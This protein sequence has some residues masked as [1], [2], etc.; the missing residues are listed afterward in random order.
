[1]RSNQAMTGPSF[2]YLDSQ[3]RA[4][5]MYPEGRVFRQSKVFASD[6]ACLTVFEAG[7]RSNPTVLLI[8]ALGMSGLFLAPLAK[9]LSGRF[10]IVT[11]ESRGLPDYAA[12]IGEL[13]LSIPRHA[14]DAAQILSN[15]GTSPEAVIAY[16]SGSN[17]AVQALADGVVQTK[18]MCLVSPSIALPNVEEKT[19]YQR[20]MLPIWKKVSLGGRK[21][22]AMVRSLIQQNR[23]EFD[24]SLEA[25]LAR[26]NNL[27]F[28]NDDTTLRYA[29][30]QAA[31]QDLEWSER[32]T[33]LAYPS[34]VLHG[35]KD[36]IIHAASSA[37][38]AGILGNADFQ[39]IP[40][41]G[42]FAIYSSDI[43]HEQIATFLHGL[44]APVPDE[45]LSP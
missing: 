16:C 3:E 39:T 37:A 17:V 41:S 29:Q 44:E 40:Q 5:S 45:V 26:I 12:A 22:A 4:F 43:L 2:P 9:R 11:W 27:P 6:G 32:L 21:T 10:H 23:P 7:T 14:S 15:I 31:C 42:H 36:D 35:E 20:T 33:A 19:D 38:V 8:N 13:D 1:M 30:M 28:A 24:G 18:R 34:L 25:E